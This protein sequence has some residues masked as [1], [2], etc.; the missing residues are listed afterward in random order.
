MPWGF[1]IPGKVWHL[2]KSI[3]GLKQ[4]LQNYYLHMKEKLARLGS[5][6]TE[7]DSCLFISADIICLLYG[8]DLIFVYHNQAHMYD[9]VEQM[10]HKKMLFKE[11]NNMAGFLGVHIDRS[12]PDEISLTQAGLI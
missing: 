8:D 1:S 7:A 2:K 10:R 9:L 12:K 6:A 11:E 4:S 5:H 3:Y